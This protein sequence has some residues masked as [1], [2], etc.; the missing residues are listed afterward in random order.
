MNKPIIKH[1]CNGCNNKVVSELDNSNISNTY[2][3]PAYCI[4]CQDRKPTNKLIVKTLEELKE[5]IE[6]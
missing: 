6:C 5:E 4:E 1:E 3:T 2:T